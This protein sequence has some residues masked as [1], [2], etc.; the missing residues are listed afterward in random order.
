MDGTRDLTGRE[1][2][3]IVLRFLNKLCEPTERLLTIA[4]AD[5]GDAVT[6]TDTIL[7]ELTTA[8]LSPE[9]IISHVYDG[10]LLMTGKHE[11]VQKLLQQKLDREIPYVHCYNHQLHLVVIHALAVEKAVMDFSVC[12]MLYKFCR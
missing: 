1:N 8:G 5:H 10:A 9:K 11:G 2:I 6:L 12:N 7:G 3:S 4:T